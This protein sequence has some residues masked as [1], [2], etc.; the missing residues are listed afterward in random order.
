MNR[1]VCERE[2]EL[3][4]SLGRG[5]IGAELESHVVTCDPCRELQLVA[6]ALLDDR[7]HAMVEA[8]VPS[9]GTMWFRMRLRHRRDAAA[10]ARASLAIGQATTVAIAIGLIVW[11]FGG[12]LAGEFRELR[13][14]VATIR[15]S[16][17]VMI[18]LATWAVVAP[19]AGWVA[20]R[21]K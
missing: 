13:T 17:A 14:A 15:V 9:A 19:I 1:Q 21:Q 7:A 2:Q 4:D 20:I 12:Q 6:G 18:A 11:F 16:T 10:A 3:L 8:P 5:F